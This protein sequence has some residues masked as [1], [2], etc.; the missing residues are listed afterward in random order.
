MIAALL[1]AQ[2][3]YRGTEVFPPEEFAARRTQ[4]ISQIG[5]GVAHMLAIYR[6]EIDRVMGLCGLSS[7]SAIDKSILLQTRQERTT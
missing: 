5:D 6:Q 4:V 1:F 3:G 7:I 2:P